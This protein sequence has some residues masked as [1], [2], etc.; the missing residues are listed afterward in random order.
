MGASTVRG[1]GILCDRFANLASRLCASCP[2][3]HAAKDPV[4]FARVCAELP[5]MPRAHVADVLEEP[6]A[7]LIYAQNAGGGVSGCTYTGPGAVRPWGSAAKAS[8]HLRTSR[9]RSSGLRE[10]WAGARGAL[11][12]LEVLALMLVPLFR[13][14]ICFPLIPTKFATKLKFPLTGV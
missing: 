1:F 6:L 8:A 12:A 9:R 3:T 7:G 10:R 11:G 13:F 5:A 14:K 2:R 4:K